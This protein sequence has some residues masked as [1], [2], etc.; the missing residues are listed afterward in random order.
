[1]LS[2]STEYGQALRRAGMGTGLFDEFNTQQQESGTLDAPFVFIASMTYMASVDGE[3]LDEELMPILGWLGGS[4]EALLA[5]QDAMRYARETP[6]ADFLTE[7]TPILNRDQKLCLLANMLDVL[8]ADGFA[9][10]SE[11]ELFFTFCQ[12]FRVSEEEYR[13]FVQMAIIKNNRALFR[14]QAHSTTTASAQQDFTAEPVQT[15]DSGAQPS[16]ET[17]SEGGAQSHARPLDHDA[18][19]LPTDTPS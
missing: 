19:P 18:D 6:V 7:A 2:T 11:Q 12:A 5:G 8:F 3:V 16:E 10:P 14:M 4:E 13:P 17:L 9:D 1:M 15:V